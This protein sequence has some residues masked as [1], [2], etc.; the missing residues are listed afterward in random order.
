MGDKVAR[1]G[2]AR[3][4]GVPVLPAPTPRSTPAPARRRRADRLPAAG[5]GVA[6]RRRA[7]DA[8]GPR[9]GRAAAPGRG[10]HASSSPRSGG[11]SCS[12]SATSHGGATSRCRC[13]PITTARSQLGDRDCTLQRRHQKLLE[14]APAPD[15][16]CRCAPRCTRRPAGSRAPSATAAPAPSSSWSTATQGPRVPGDEHPPAGRARR[17]RTG[18]RRRPR[19]SPN[20]VSR[21]ARRSPRHRR[22]EVAVRGHAVQSRVTAEDPGRTSAL[23]RGGS[24]PPI[25]VRAV[26][27]I[28]FRASRPG[29]RCPGAYDSLLGQGPRRGG[30]PRHG[31]RAPRRRAGRPRRHRRAHHR[32]LPA[33]GA[34]P[35]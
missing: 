19:A 26:V 6:R 15:S 3:R 4:C 10:G 28:R 29:T 35:P 21:P 11:A 23:H 33:R 14:E 31:V 13:W 9:A 17:H 1:T 34:R 16:R 24:R 25:A 27:A 5:Q 32:G 22:G 2:G 30:R 7:R 12:S 20:S 8:R 18:D